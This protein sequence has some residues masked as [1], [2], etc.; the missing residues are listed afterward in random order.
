MNIKTIKAIVH[1]APTYVVFGAAAYQSFWHSIHVAS[2]HGASDP[3]L[4]PVSIDG[5]LIT[6]SR[7]VSHARTRGA[8]VLAFAVMIVGMAA[9]LGINA[10]AAPRGDLVGLAVSVWPGVGMILTAALIHWA[11]QRATPARR[12]RPTAK[13]VTSINRHKRTA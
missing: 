4:V 10:L 7:Y 3:W 5:V 11:P 12:R 13:N 6:A 8:R 1:A 2:A 9:T